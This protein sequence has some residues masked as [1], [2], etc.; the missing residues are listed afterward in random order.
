MNVKSVRRYKAPDYPTRLQVM[1]DHHLLKDHLPPTWLKYPEVKGAFVLLLSAN[2]MGCSSNTSS[3]VSPPQAVVAPLFQHGEGRGATGCV[4]V[5][6][7]VFLSEEEA[8]SLIRE[9]LNQAGLD[10]SEDDVSIDGVQTFG[11]KAYHHRILGRSFSTIT[12]ANGSERVF[13]TDLLDAEQKLAVEFVSVNDY[14]EL[15]GLQSDSTVQGFDLQESSRF[16]AS[17]VKKDGQ[18]LTFAAFYDPMADLNMSRVPNQGPEDWQKNYEKAEENARVES[19]ELL[20]Q[21]VK[22]FIDWLKAQGLL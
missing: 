13:K 16:I 19:K 11:R 17:Q 15:G 22:D 18:D 3:Q 6:P 9:E 8:I 7:P 1:A 20:R 12:K 21:Q 14:A 10:M 2:L 4:V 5:S